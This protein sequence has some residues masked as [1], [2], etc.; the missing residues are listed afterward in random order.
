ANFPGTPWPNC[1]EID[2]ME[3]INTQTTTY[4]TIHWDAGGY[5]TYGGNTTVATP[6]AFHTYAIEWNSSSIKWF[7]DGTQ[8]VEANILNNINSTEEFHKP[9]FIILYL[10]VG[11]NWPG[12]PNGTTPSPARY[13]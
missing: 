11:G 6:T 10:A 7:L 9:F 3:H 1:G 4:G 5:A 13:Q 12:S 2:I 8:F